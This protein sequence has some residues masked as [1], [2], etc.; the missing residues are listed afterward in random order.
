M[1]N[2]KYVVAPIEPLFLCAYDT[3]GT[4]AFTTTTYS[5]IYS[6]IDLPGEAECSIYKKDMLDLVFRVNKRKTGLKYIDEN[7]TITTSSGWTPS[8]FLSLRVLK[9]K[10]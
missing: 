10:L 6:V 1:L 5:G 2:T 4:K 3:Y 8:L 9:A 7:L